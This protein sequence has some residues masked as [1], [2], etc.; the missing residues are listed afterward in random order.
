MKSLIVI[1]LIS[2]GFAARAEESTYQRQMRWQ[3]E[4]QT[5]IMQQQL[6]LQ[7]KQMRQQEMEMN[8]IQGQINRQN[9]GW[10]LS[11]IYNK[12]YLDR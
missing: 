6:E 9:G 2:L 1:L 12:L 3:V 8:R 11:P 7:Q 5:R 10:D 4:E